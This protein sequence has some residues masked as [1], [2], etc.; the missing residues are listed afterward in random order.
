[1]NDFRLTESDK[2]SAL[3]LRLREHFEQ[4]LTG[5]RLRNDDPTLDPAATAALRG[6]IK[7]LKLLT[8]LDADRPSI[9]G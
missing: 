7:V 3:W 1:M 2:A 8:R 4:R 5:A 6:E 9:D